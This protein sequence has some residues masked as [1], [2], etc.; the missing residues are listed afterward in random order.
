MKKSLV[1]LAVAGASSFALPSF[2]ADQVIK[3][4]K[5]E[6]LTTEKLH[7]FALSALAKR[8]Y[9]IEQDTPTMIVG[10]QAK[11]KVE[12]VIEPASITIRWKEGFGKDKDYW[13]TNL[14]T[15]VLWSLAE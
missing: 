13:L 10:E 8:K 4:P 1:A 11:T 7:E 12:I 2:A 15:D 6:A 3:L 5:C 14:K 9:N